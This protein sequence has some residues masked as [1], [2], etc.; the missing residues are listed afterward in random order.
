MLILKPSQIEYISTLVE[1]GGV[2]PLNVSGNSMK[3]FISSSGDTV[4]LSKCKKEEIKKGDILLYTRSDGSVVLHRVW[5]KTKTRL[6][7]NGD[8]QS[9]LEFLN[10]DS[11]IAK[12]DSYTHNGKKRNPNSAN[13]K[14]LQG[15]WKPTL[16]VRP[17][18]FAGLRK[19]HI[20]K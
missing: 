2:V 9:S 6:V 7:M 20:I 3:P 16:K 1:S 11:V 8:S 5:N 18:I 19:L 12:V 15:L 10:Y 4:Y 13:L 17:Y 14:V